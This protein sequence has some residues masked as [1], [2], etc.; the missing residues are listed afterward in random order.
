MI[1]TA[2]SLF[3]LAALA[4]CAIPGPPPAPA[5]LPQVAANAGVA[6]RRINGDVGAPSAPP[7]AQVSYAVA[8]TL[9]P[10]S[11]AGEAAT[12]PGEISLDFADTDIR[13]VVAQILGKV[14]HVPYTI[15]PAVR[16]TTT[17][18]SPMPL[19]RSQM[20]PTLAALLAQNGATLARAD[21]I[22]RVLTAKDA[23]TAPG[24]ATD[25]GE[26]GLTV[27]PLRYAASDEIAKVLQP[28][29]GAGKVT[30]DPARNAVVVSGDPATRDT[31]VRLVQS[32]DIDLL[33]GQSYALLPVTSGNAKDFATALQDALRGQT[34]GQTGGKPSGGEGGGVIRVVPMERIGAVLAIATQPRLLDD[35]RRVYAMI[36]RK[37]RETLRSWHVFYLQNSHANSVASILQQAFTPNNVTAQP[38]TASAVG[39]TA[40]GMGAQQLGG[41]G[42]AGSPGGGGTGMG[43]GMGGGIGGGGIGGGGMGGG[44]IGGGI[45]GSA[46]AAP[47]AAP[48]AGA[49]GAP[50][51]SGNPLLGPLEAPGNVDVN[52]M[53]IIPN[54]QNNALLIYATQQEEDTIEAMLRK[55]DILPL[56]VR[57]D[58]TIAEVDL[59]DQLQFGTQFFFK[60]GG[61]N[62]VLTQVLPG[63]APG[64]LLAGNNGAQLTLAALQAVTTVHVLSSPEVLVLDNQPATLQVGDAVP[65][66]TSSSQSTLVANSPVINT[67]NYAQTGV[68]MQVTPRVNSGGLVTL[69]VAQQ[70]SEVDTSVNTNGIPSP[71]FLERNVQSRVVVQDGQTV[72]LAG[73]IRDSVTRS[74]E[75]V[76]FLK[77][78][79][80]LGALLGQQNNTRTRTELL[81]LIT[82]HVLH[83]QRDA[84]AL[85]EDLREHLPEAA[86]VPYELGR[87]RPDGSP[88]PTRA[89]RQRTGLDQ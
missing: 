69:D 41:L 89:L 10:P 18:H 85:T 29:A 73:L 24:L 2:T 50:P 12:G 63:A 19:A 71:A 37:Q 48:Q 11:R 77:D 6:A 40:P 49:A 1:R 64:F 27:V 54:P 16:G 45:G 44:G 61:L 59:N 86:R 88:D 22:Y 9:A 26:L 72:G 15:D 83:D 67:V 58:A 28:Y 43:G 34:G 38:S 55:I 80:L 31:L 32:F 75:G 51:A 4:G 35:V 82:P 52:D 7:P 46:G 5:P 76:P 53:R 30:A 17:F 56:Q 8:A 65:Y 84:R 66:L 62:G 39:T 47:L 87:L 23:A 78:I 20:L 21:G 74:N 60:Q 36:E 25:A 13:E 70:V 33:A 57:I 81:V 3:A 68:I 14:L 42:S 79:P